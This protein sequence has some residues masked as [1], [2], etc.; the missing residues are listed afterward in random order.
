MRYVQPASA[1]RDIPEWADTK[2]TAST[3]AGTPRASR[4]AEVLDP[5][6]ALSN[7]GNSR[8]L[9]AQATGVDIN[10]DHGTDAVARE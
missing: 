8:A 4:I 7:G 9:F 3:R 1:G 2:I 5:G 6:C 10:L